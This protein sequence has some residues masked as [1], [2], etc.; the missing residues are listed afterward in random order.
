MLIIQGWL[1]APLILTCLF[2]FS[3]ARVTPI[4]AGIGVARLVAG[5][6]RV[7]FCVVWASSN[8][9]FACNATGPD[10]VQ[11]LEQK[12]A[13]IKNDA[14]FGP[15]KRGPIFEPTTCGSNQFSLKMVRGTKNGAKKWDPKMVHQKMKKCWQ[16]HRE[17]IAGKL[18]H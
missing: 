2:G 16:K 1:A 4:L 14:I 11:R 13:K 17:I 3:C 6:F 9:C 15:Q 12:K 5:A 8:Q 7:L 10:A 18:L